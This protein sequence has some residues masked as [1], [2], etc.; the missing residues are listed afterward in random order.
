MNHFARSF[1][2]KSCLLS[3]L[4]FSYRPDRAPKGGYFPVLI[5]MVLLY[6]LSSSV[7]G[8]LVSGG[9]AGGIVLLLVSHVSVSRH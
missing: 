6:E 2:L 1:L 4:N 5:G 8:A 9:E 3:L 7:S